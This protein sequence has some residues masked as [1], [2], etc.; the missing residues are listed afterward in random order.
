M[1]VRFFKFF[2]YISP[3]V[4][5]EMIRRVSMQHLPGLASEMAFTEILAL[6]PAI[7]AIFTA[8]GLFETLKGRFLQMIGQ[9]SGVVP[10]EA[11]RLIENFATEVSSDRNSS[12]F[13]VSFVLAIWISSS[14]LGA[15]MRAMD[16]IH[17]IPPKKRRPYWKSKLIAIGLTVAVI[18]LVVIATFLVFISN[19][20]INHLLE[21]AAEQRDLLEQFGLV[22]FQAMTWPLV[23][24]IMSSV[25]AFIY[26]FGPS[27]P[28]PGKPIF[29][30]A[31]L[32]AASWAVMSWGFRLYVSQYGNYNRV[33]GAVGAVIILM[34]WLYISSLIML[35]G[36]QLN[37]VVGER[38]QM[39]LRHQKA[40][41][42][43]REQI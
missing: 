14:A 5:R 16:Q 9:L 18:I 41:A 27:R 6:F 20:L 36:D 11:F 15:A 26:R 28:S 13:S 24:L 12:L 17:Q 2:Q 19:M 22:L 21:R 33:Y 39:D 37:V 8:I 43:S 31:V 40:S 35:I 1:L 23:L 29:P 3:G 10:S 32:A 30:G 25:F 4:V 42:Y 7:L 38:I 34:L